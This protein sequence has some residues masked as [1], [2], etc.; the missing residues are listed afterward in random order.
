MDDFGLGLILAEEARR[1]ADGGETPAHRAEQ[2]VVIERKDFLATAAFTVNDGQRSFPVS[3]VGTIESL[4]LITDT[5]DY[6]ITVEL[7]TDSDMAGEDESSFLARESYADLRELSTEL[8]S[9]A[10]YE[11]DSGHYLLDIGPV[12]FLDNVRVMVYPDS[13]LRVYRQRAEI[14]IEREIE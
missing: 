5:E 6:S 13:K 9:V 14:S 11:T 1:G 4:L 8:S 3:G 7:D 10:A 12:N 2:S